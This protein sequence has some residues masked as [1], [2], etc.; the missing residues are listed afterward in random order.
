MRLEVDQPA[1]RGEG[2]RLVLEAERRLVAAKPVVAIEQAGEPEPMD[3]GPKILAGMSHLGRA[4]GC[5]PASIGG[6]AGCLQRQRPAR[7]AD[8]VRE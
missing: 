1:H 8:G 7:P 5:S 6:I 2:V 3:A 4:G